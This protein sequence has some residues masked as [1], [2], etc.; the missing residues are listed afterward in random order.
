MKNTQSRLVRKK[1]KAKTP[2]SV[3]P[4]EQQV[5]G[6]MSHHNGKSGFHYLCYSTGGQ[7][8]EFPVIHLEVRSRFFNNKRTVKET[9]PIKETGQHTVRS[10][11]AIV[12]KFTDA[13]G[14]SS[15]PLA[16]QGAMNPST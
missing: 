11:S 2:T 1:K 12:A 4:I 9:F 8:N 16:A 14:Y 3:S 10:R 15:L 13:C 7:S 6:S 5:R